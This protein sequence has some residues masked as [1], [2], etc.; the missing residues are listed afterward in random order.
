MN[1]QRTPDS[2]VG[3]VIRRN[4][5]RLLAERGMSAS[6][7]YKGAGISRGQYSRIFKATNGPYLVTLQKL[8]EFLRVDAG[9]LVR[10]P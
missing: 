1:R 5:N 8:A 7:L 6:D 10:E 3:A 9:D 4:V 2:K